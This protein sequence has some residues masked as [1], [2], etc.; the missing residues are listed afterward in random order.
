MTVEDA[1]PE[2][3][4]LRDLTDAR[5]C[6][7]SGLLTPSSCDSPPTE[8]MLAEARA[9]M[10]KGERLSGDLEELRKLWAG[11]DSALASLRSAGRR[12]DR[13]VSDAL[14]RR[15]TAPGSEFA[16][17]CRLVARRIADGRPLPGRAGAPSAAT[18]R[19][20]ATSGLTVVAVVHQPRGEI[21]KLID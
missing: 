1:N 12:L 3:R 9:A 10:Q 2:F 15:A 19:A 6:K 16:R 11:S 21:F 18:L 14:A 5:N 20:L 7:R 13:Y 17:L 8:E 4:M